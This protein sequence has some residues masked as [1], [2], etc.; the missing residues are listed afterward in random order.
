MEGLFDESRLSLFCAYGWVDRSVEVAFT[1]AAAPNLPAQTRNQQRQKALTDF[2]GSLQNATSRFDFAGLRLRFEDTL[3]TL[4]TSKITVT[5]TA[6][7]VT[8]LAKTG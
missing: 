5:L 8:Q 4:N 3:E 7:Q 1:E 2:L 6:A